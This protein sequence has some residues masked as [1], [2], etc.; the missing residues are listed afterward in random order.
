MKNIWLIGTGYMAI[1]Y[2]K[3]LKALDINFITIGRGKNNTDLFK[4]ATGCEVISGGV[5]K[6][7]ES[8]PIIP[9]GVI[10]AVGVQELASITIQ[11]IKFGVK[12]IL[13]EK[14][15]ICEYQEIKELVN[16]T[17][18][19]RAEVV[20]AYNRRFYASVITA[21]EIVRQDGGITSFNFEFTEWGHEIEKLNKPKIVLE[22]WFLAN[23]SHVVDTAF[24]LGGKPTSIN[25]YTSGSLKWHPSTSRFT[26]A[27]ITDSNALFSYQANW[28][29]PGRWGVE[30]LTQRHRLIFKP[31]ETLQVQKI[32]SFAIEPVV[33]DDSL[34]KKYKP[35]IFMQT[36]AFLDNNFDRFCTIFEQKDMIEK[37]YLQMSGYKN[38]Q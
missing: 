1:E 26:G 16:V 38:S 5:E 23:S 13:L 30:I 4:Q 19:N 20:I 2:A 9:D 25:C 22:N 11:L 34:D 14:P 7:L 37:Y 36:K 6:Y 27:G 15:G 31:M 32:G 28:A 35:G 12:K 21:E 18:E 24:F 10:I 8:K 29:A 3:V 17:I 33:I